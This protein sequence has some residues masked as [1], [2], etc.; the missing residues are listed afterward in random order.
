MKVALGRSPEEEYG[1]EL[2]KLAA[3]VT[4]NVGL[5]LTNKDHDQVQQ[6]FADLLIHDFAKSGFVATETVK[7]EKQQLKNWPGSMLEQVRGPGLPVDLNNG[8]LEL[9]ENY[10]VC[11]KGETLS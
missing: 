5:L 2:A 1:D 8:V 10:T 6:Y 9:R 3:D 11:K 4:G 7:L